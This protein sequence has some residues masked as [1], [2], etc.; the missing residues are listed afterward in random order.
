LTGTVGACVGTSAPLTLATS[1]TIVPDIN[2]LR[3]T[4]PLC[5]NDTL[6][7][8]VN[9]T[10][11]TYQWKKDG[12]NLATTKSVMID[13]NGAGVYTIYVTA[14]GGCNGTSL[15]ITVTVKPAPAKP[16]ITI[17]TQTTMTSSASTG[18]QWYY[19]GS[20][21]PNAVGT[22]YTA[23]TNGNYYV[24]VTGANGCTAKSDVK[25]IK[26][27]I[28]EL[29]SDLRFDVYPNPTT[30]KLNIIGNFKTQGDVS[31]RI[32]DLMGKLVYD[33]NEVIL[34]GK[35]EKQIDLQGKATG[36]YFVII[37]SEGRQGMMK[38]ILK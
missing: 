3:G 15:P 10:F 14:A 8:E 13:K 31:I 24:V 29:S 19:N 37:S 25:N 9:G 16:T 11:L 28:L 6:K 2:I 7:L 32:S 5:D 4:N 22:S 26:T 30:G 17:T 12:V 20:P 38:L 35:F 36:I 34:P 18:N 21:I 23:M 27:S 33:K 1:S